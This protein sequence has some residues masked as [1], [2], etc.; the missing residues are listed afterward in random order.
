MKRKTHPL[1]SALIT[2]AL[3]A[4]TSLAQDG[5]R[6]RPPG[7]PEGRGN[8]AEMLKRADT[9]G[10]GKVSKAEFIKSRT[11]ELEEAFARID[12]NADGFIDEVEVKE[13][14]ERMRAGMGREGPGGPPEGMRRPE[15]EG[16]GRPEGEGRGR[17]ESEG[18]RRPPEG[19]GRGGPP[20][21]MR[22]PEGEGRG[23][24]EGEGRGGPPEG[25]RR[26][27]GGAA[28]IMGDQAFA[29]MDQN[30]DGQ[31]SKEEFEQGMARMREMMGRAGMGRG[32][33]RGP[34]APGGP[35]AE[36]GFRRPPSP[37][38]Q[39]K[40]RPRPELEGDAPKKDA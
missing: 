39:G 1:F 30:G 31:L 27:E 15:G 38:G 16:R 40:G 32:E 28:A 3:I 21:G 8:P 12:A 9:D 19:E 29:R 24:P 4:T 20:E 5:E 34:G 6:P 37:E 14:A 23:R 11:A 26:P 36:G 22:R 13:I 18:F 25:M 17:P 7:G 35:G 2:S 33:G 10:D